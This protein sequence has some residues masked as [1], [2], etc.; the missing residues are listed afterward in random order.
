[1][2]HIDTTL[3]RV[4]GVI[5]EAFLS[6]DQVKQLN[7]IYEAWTLEHPALKNRLKK[8]QQ[9]LLHGQVVMTELFAW[10]VKGASGWHEVRLTPTGG[11]CDC[12]WW[13][14][15]R[16]RCSHLLAA[17][18]WFKLF[19]RPMVLLLKGLSSSRSLTFSTQGTH[20]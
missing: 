2:Y 13:T 4:R 11:V 18:L 3:E 7:E 15:R 10:K 14:L 16:E 12:E 9:L 20:P 5:M 17:G 8:A 6:H 19:G 1:M